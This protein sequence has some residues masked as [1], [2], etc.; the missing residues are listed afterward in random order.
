[1]DG[2]YVLQ[3]RIQGR[4]EPFPTGDGLEDL[5][6]KWNLFLVPQG[7]G[8]SGGYGGA[9]VGG[10]TDLTGSVLN[11]AG[12]ATLGCCFHENL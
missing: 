4:S 11:S 2:P 7:Y 9:M 8:V 1:M 3:R 10:T 6:L 12:G 5:L